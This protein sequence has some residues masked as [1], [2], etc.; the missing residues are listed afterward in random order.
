M[1]GDMERVT[2]HFRE[3]NYMKIE[4]LTHF[5]ERNSMEV[6]YGTLMYGT[7][8][9]ETEWENIHNV[10]NTSEDKT[11]QNYAMLQFCTVQITFLKGAKLYKGMVSEHFPWSDPSGG[12]VHYG[13]V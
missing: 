7:V 10:A 11:T 8:R 6:R 13:T 3:Q 9:Y 2:L 4:G 5:S 12:T 1:V